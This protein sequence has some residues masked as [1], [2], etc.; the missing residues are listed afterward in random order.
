V[1]DITDTEFL[2]RW[3]V[4]DLWCTPLYYQDALNRWPERHAAAISAVARAQPGGVLIHCVRGVD[5]TGI[6]TILLLAA[7]GVTTDDIVA[8]YE[9]SVDPEREVILARE[10]TTTRDVIL[11]TLASLDIEPYL[12]KGGL[13]RTDLDAVRTRLLE[14]SG[15]EGEV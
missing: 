14:P 3:A 15:S 7:V 8:D 12:R 9:L 4:S 2:H 1:E 13:S 5:R 10:H 6:V 11:A